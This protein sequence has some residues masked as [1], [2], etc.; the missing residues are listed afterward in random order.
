MSLKVKR[1]SPDLVSALL[2]KDSLS[3]WSSKSGGELSSVDE[4][5][6]EKST[7]RFSEPDSL[8]CPSQTCTQELFDSLQ[9]KSNLPVVGQSSF[10]ARSSFQF[11][12]QADPAHRARDD[13]VL[14]S[15]SGNAFHT[16]PLPAAEDALFALGFVSP[17]TSPAVS[18]AKSLDDETASRLNTRSDNISSRE[19]VMMGGQEC[20]KDTKS[21][22]KQLEESLSVPGHRKPS[23]DS[24][25]RLQ[26]ELPQQ[27]GEHNSVRVSDDAVASVVDDVVNDVV[28]ENMDDVMDD[29][30]Q[31]S[32]EVEAERC[33]AKATVDE[34]ESEQ[35]AAEC[36][37]VCSATEAERSSVDMKAINAVEHSHH[38]QR[39]Q[40]KLWVA[41][42]IA[43]ECSGLLIWS[44]LLCNHSP[45]YSHSLAKCLHDVLICQEEIPVL[46]CLADCLERFSA[47]VVF[48]SLS[49]F[50][51]LVVRRPLPHSS[52]PVLLRMVF[53]PP[54]MWRRSTEIQMMSPQAGRNYKDLFGPFVRWRHVACHNN[55]SSNPELN[56]VSTF[57]CTT[58]SWEGHWSYF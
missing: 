49:D 7:E 48:C 41:C 20:R 50:E 24:H 45:Q 22:Q 19:D 10:F 27:A 39:S 40:G 36:Q 52:L 56:S 30:V 54:F 57:R 37:T 23:L 55:L 38:Y 35:C 53:P 34:R 47:F 51:L 3:D 13:S 58:S 4:S 8:E 46:K 15:F 42:A 1:M 6:R 9:M 16:S 29:G 26:E 5:D 44:T 14:E 21:G 32:D 43:V 25:D 18:E 33:S 12:R 17:P 28:Q 31:E 2:K 11:S